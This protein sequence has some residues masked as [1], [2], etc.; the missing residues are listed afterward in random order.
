MDPDG[1][2]GTAQA[3]SRAR[4]RVR[5]RCFFV[6]AAAIVAVA[7]GLR[8]YRLGFQELWMDEGVSFGMATVEDFRAALRR[9]YNPPVYYLLQRLWLLPFGESEAALRSLS[10]VFGTLFVAAIIWGGRVFLGPATGLWSGALAAIAPLHIYYSQ[11]ARP[12]ALL[13]LAIVLITITLWRAVQVGTWSRWLAFSSCTLFA[14]ATHYF[15]V[16][17][18]A[19]AGLLVLLWPAAVRGDRRWRRY[20]AA[21]VLGT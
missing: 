11:E 3:P 12:Y 7:A 19:P 17:V 15:A 21:S 10:A 20:A 2:T 6:A 14:L 8:F 5:D 9:E 1:H 4:G 18:L 13:S 16:L